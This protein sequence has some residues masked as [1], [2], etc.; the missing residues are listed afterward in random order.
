MDVTALKS[1]SFQTLLS[2]AKEPQELLGTDHPGGKNQI[3]CLSLKTMTTMTKSGRFLFGA[4]LLV[5][6]LVVSLSI[7]LP[8]AFNIVEAA[9]PRRRV[10]IRRERAAYDREITT[11]TEDGR[12]AQV[13]YGLEA[14]MRGST[15][16]AIQ[17]RL[18]SKEEDDNNESISSCII[19]CIENSSFG[20]MHRIDDH[21][22]MLTAGLAGD[23]RMLANQARRACQNHRLRYGEA[24][25]TKQ[26]ARTTAEFYHQLT[27]MGGCRPLGCTAILMGVDGTARLFRTD[28][29]GGIEECRFCA[30]G[31]SQDTVGR[32]LMTLVEN[33]DGEAP[34]DNE[35][36][37][38]G[39]ARIAAKM[40]E[41]FL[42]LLDKSG[43]SKRAKLEDGSTLDVWTIQPMKQRRGE[44][45]ATCYSGV[46]KENLHEIVLKRT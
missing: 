42:R 12:L 25:T 21:I 40:A 20:K 8:C 4:F 44:M 27:R 17:V 37:S 2:F 18:P 29:G 39:I 33:L 30:A 32:E 36:R 34:K 28:P 31:N 38:K 45:L 23:A 41:T 26:A 19:V 1:L 14:S 35:S 10:T 15:V 5:P 22:W 6:Y 16:G 43:K 3:R 9:H 46:D 13:E 24:P 7:F 11:F